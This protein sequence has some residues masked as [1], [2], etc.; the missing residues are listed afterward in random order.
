MPA[1]RGKNVVVEFGGVDIS[2]DGRSVNY[3]QSSDPLDT[4]VYG[5]DERTKTPGLLDGSGGFEG[6]DTTGDWT[7]AWEAIVP[8]A[9]GTLAIYPE[10]KTEGQRE[11]TFTAII[12]NRSLTLPYDELAT[13]SLSF[14]ISGPVSEGTYTEGGL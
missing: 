4:T 10:G 5:L 14:E 12:T 7:A 11:V 3:E 6:L 2:G 1:Y 9:S 8:G 13:V